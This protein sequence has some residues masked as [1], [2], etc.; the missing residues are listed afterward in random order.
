MNHLC[1]IC[2]TNQAT[3]FYS[4]NG[5][6]IV[7]CAA[8]HM[9]FVSPIPTSEELTAHYQNAAYF[10]GE[11]EQGYLNYAD[12]QKALRPHFQRRL[13]VIEAR[14]SQRGKILDVGCAAGYFLEEAQQRGWQICGMELSQEM[15]DSAEQLLHVPIYTELAAVPDR[16]FDVITLWEVIEHLPDPINTLRQ[17]RDRLR[18]GG[19]LMLSTPNNRHWQALR[20]KEQWVGYRPPSHLQYFTRETL[21]DTLRR[22]GFERSDISGTAPL[23]PLPG[24]L[25]RASKPLEQALATGQARPWK[26]ALFT[27]RGIRVAGWGWQ[28]I[29]HRSDDIFATLEALAL[30]P[31]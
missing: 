11:S 17:L 14:L 9:R 20:A 29:A 26:L 2:Q 31:Q 7:E 10:E 25:S 1:P 8:C 21:G 23:P 19:M 13:Q 12:M 22:A 24:W 6:S 30:R 4:K 5:Y 27:W 18:P 3:P 28:K 15:A 16:D